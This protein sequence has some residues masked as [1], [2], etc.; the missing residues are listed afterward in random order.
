MSKIGYLNE[1]NHFEYRIMGI[2]CD[3]NYKNAFHKN[4]K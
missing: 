4:K 3:M 1:I 2:I